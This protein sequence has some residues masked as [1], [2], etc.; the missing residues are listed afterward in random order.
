MR[1]QRGH[2]HRMEHAARY[3]AEDEFAQPGMPVSAHDHEARGCICY[4]R[5]QDA[6]NVDIGCDEM[7][8]LRLDAMTHEMICHGGVFVGLMT[9]AA[10]RDQIYMLGARQEG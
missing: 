4:I 1:H 6:R 5:K 7:P 9:R 8:E 2:G 3:A 10:H